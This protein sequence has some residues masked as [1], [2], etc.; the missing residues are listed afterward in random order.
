[1]ADSLQHAVAHM[2][3]EHCEELIAQVSQTLI[4]RMPM[5]GISAQATD[6]LERHQQ[7]MALTARRFHQIV[8][9]GATIDWSLVEFEY[10]W[11]GRKLR[12][13]GMS[14]EHHEILIDAYFSSALHMHNWS[15]AEC[16]MLGQIAAR[17]RE[18]AEEAYCNPANVV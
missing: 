14:W 9:A 6:R 13:M 12:S 8:Q 4:H 15:P 5:L 1:M 7:N 17:V 10:D 18:V 16:D 11:A 3:D 2:L